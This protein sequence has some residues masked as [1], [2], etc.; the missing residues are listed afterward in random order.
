MMSNTFI[1]ELGT[2]GTDGLVE[3]DG[4]VV[5]ITEEGRPFMRLACATLDR[6][7][8]SGGAR[9]SSAV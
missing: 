8:N 5:R 2:V 7:L 3:I 6:Y 4:A 9:H 1:R